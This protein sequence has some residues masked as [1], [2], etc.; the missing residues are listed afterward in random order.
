MVSTVGPVPAMERL[1]AEFPSGN[2][3]VSLLTAATAPPLSVTFAVCLCTTLLRRFEGIE[4]AQ[5]FSS[6]APVFRPRRP[7][8]VQDAVIQSGLTRLADGSYHHTMKIYDFP[9]APNPRRV[10]IF[11]AEKSVQMVYVH[12]DLL[13]GENRTVE[14]IQKNPLAALPVLEFDDGTYLTESVAICRYFESLYPQP[15]L[16]GVDPQDSAFVE[17]WT[18]R[19]ELEISQPIGNFLQHTHPAFKDRTQQFPEF[20]EARR[21]YGLKRIEWLDSILAQRQFVAGDRYTIADIIAQVAID[22]GLKL[23]GLKLPDGARHVKHWHEAVSSRP[24]AKA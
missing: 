7:A 1:L 15:P 9:L 14:F 13:K 2:S 18:R 21:D 19:M 10:R 4:R 20:G 12:V 11:L 17:M 16:M 24:S 23:G 8:V 3:A 6:K 5:G 22:A